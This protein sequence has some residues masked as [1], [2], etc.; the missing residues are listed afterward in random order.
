MLRL[1]P[2]CWADRAEF[3]IACSRWRMRR[4][5][6]LAISDARRFWQA[7]VHMLHPSPHLNICCCYSVAACWDQGRPML[8]KCILKQETHCQCHG[9][10]VGTRQP[11]DRSQPDAAVCEAMAG[12]MPP[13]LGLKD[14]CRCI[15]DGSIY[16]N[17]SSS[18][19]GQ[20]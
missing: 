4:A 11:A 17:G 7:V 8:H 6:I 13:M 15:S 20:L 16:P 12:K 19:R 9:V 18:Y 14:Q 3:C 1:P 10:H 2:Y 5:Y